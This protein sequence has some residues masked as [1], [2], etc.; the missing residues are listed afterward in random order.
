MA[1]QI[2]T[3]Y[4]TQSTSMYG[5]NEV[6]VNDFN[7]A[8]S[9]DGKPANCVLLGTIEQEIEIP[10]IDLVMAE[11]ENLEQSIQHERAQSQSKV[12]ILL[13][14]ISKLKAIGHDSPVAAEFVYSGG[15]VF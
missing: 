4:I 6:S 14:R 8:K 3:L 5:G 9:Y 2:F 1:K 13:D 11:I 12:N 7:M 15:E 10:E